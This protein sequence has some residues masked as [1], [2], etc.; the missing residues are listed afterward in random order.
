VFALRALA[1]SIAASLLLALPGAASAG[2]RPATTRPA[3]ARVATT[4]VAAHPIVAGKAARLLP[5][6]SAA[7]PADAPPQVQ[8]AVWA[9]NA[10]QDK[11][12]VYGGGHGGF[13]ASGY[14][15]SG[16][17]SYVLHAAG[18]L[19]SPLDSSSFMR[20]GAAG[21][22]RWITVY[23]NRGH[24]WASIAGLRLDTSRYGVSGALSGAKAA[25]SGPRWR[26]TGRP[27]SGFVRRH[28]AGL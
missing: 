7:A 27:T 1:P 16:T 28:P 3:T 4:R 6:G 23:A 21:R 8:A 26:P 9:A 18:L 13:D 2:A 12:Y 25:E 17:V 5:D 15:C 22:G 24:A 14:D 20:W 10:L 19:S 11:P